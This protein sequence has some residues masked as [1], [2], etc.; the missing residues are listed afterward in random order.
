MVSLAYNIGLGNFTKS[1]L[2]RKHNAKCWQCAAAQFGVWRNAGGKVMTGLIRRRAAERWS[3][4]SDKVN[5]EYAERKA[6]AEAAQAKSNS[7]AE[8]VRVVTETKYRTVYRDVIK[9]VQ[10]PNRTVCKFDDA[11]VQLR[12]QAIDAANAVSLNVK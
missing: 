4:H 6:R 1:T 3:A 5:K 10:D 7:K 12:Q 8:E 2:L 11:A 9:Y